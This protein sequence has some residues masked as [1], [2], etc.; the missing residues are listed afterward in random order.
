MS[1]RKVP[2]SFYLSYISIPSS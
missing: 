2:S 1:Q